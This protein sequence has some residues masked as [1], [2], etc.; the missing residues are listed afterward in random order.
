[1]E[2]N[3]N[4]KA[5]FAEVHGRVQ[6]VG[7]R[8][9]AQDEARRLRL[10]GWVRNTDYGTVEVFVQGQKDRIDTFLQWLHKGPSGARVDFVDSI[11]KQLDSNCTRFYIDRSDEFD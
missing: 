4:Q 5:F 1:M 10:N 8:F 6:N 2:T 7:F 9:A 11:E 3:S